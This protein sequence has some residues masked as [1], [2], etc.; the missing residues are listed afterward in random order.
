MSIINK[1]EF[2]LLWLKQSVKELHAKLE[3]INQNSFAK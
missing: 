2:I 1:K 3:A